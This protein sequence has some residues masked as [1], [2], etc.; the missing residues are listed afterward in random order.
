MRLLIRFEFDGTVY[1]GWQIQPRD[2][3]VQGEIEK[4]LQQMCG[5]HISITGAGRT[6]AGVHAACM[7]AHLDINPD[8]LGRI[9]NGLNTMLP[10]NISCV[11][12]EQVADDFHARFHAVSRSYEY[13]IGSGRHPL[14]GRYEYQPGVFNLDTDAMRTAA[15]LSLGHSNWRGFA[16]EGGGNTTWDMNVLSTSVVEN[17]GG[18]TLTI[19]AN[20]FLR[21]VVRIWS[22]TIF[23]IGTGRISPETVKSI[24]DTTDKR[25]AGPSL[26]ASG[27]ILTEVRYPPP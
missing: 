23:R 12:V 4:A 16:R 19:T 6:D 14:K 10:R 21:G 17:N 27:L 25:L 9:E 11:S 8:E 2:I 20:R 1:S 18:W 24:L 7:P 15:E 13:H 5:R 26:P 22:G 3:T